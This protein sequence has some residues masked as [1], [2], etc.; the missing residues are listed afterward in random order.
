MEEG[1]TVKNNQSR[2]ENNLYWVWSKDEVPFP[3]ENQV[4]NVIPKP[5][6]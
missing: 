4:N 5:G 1:I 6:V 2:E 3:S